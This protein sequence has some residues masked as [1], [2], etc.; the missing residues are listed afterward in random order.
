MHPF[1]LASLPVTT[2]VKAAKRHSSPHGEQA[3]YAGPELLG[4]VTW[5]AGF[6]HATLATGRRLGKFRRPN[7]AMAAICSAAREILT[8]SGP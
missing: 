1:V 2:R 8:T 6:S 4:V 3:I 7:D 5:R